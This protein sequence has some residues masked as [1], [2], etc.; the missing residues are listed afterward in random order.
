MFRVL[1]EV[2]QETSDIQVCREEEAGRV[3]D[4]V[5]MSSGYGDLCGGQG[6]SEPVPGLSTEEVSGQGNEQRWSVSR[7]ESVIGQGLAV[8]NERQ[9]RNTATIR[10]TLDMDPHNFFRSFMGLQK[11]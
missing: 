4:R 11:I 3:R 8:Q 6:A 2:R 7:G 10:P 9:P 1:Q 5:Q